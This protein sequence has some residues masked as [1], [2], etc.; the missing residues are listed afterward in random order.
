[1]PKI[2][3][4]ERDVQRA[5]IDL[6]RIKGWACYRINNGAVYNAKSG[7]WVYHGT[8]GVCDL[9]AFKQG[10]ALYIECKSSTGKPTADQLKFLALADGSK[11]QAVVIK[12]ISEL[13]PIV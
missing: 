10:K 1:M 3:H 5:C 4:S 9:I 11:A 12:D 7:A 8:P 13:L 6:L 2:K